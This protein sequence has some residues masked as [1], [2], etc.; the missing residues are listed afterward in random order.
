[1]KI[2]KKLFSVVLT[3]ILSVFAIKAV[4]AEGNGTITVKNATVGKTYEIYKIFDLTYS[5]AKVAYTIDSDW[6]LFFN[7]VG[8]KYIVDTNTT[9][10]LN[11]ITVNGVT[12]Y[13]NITDGTTGNV[14]EF[15]QDALAYIASKMTTNDLGESVPF[16]DGE[17]TAT[18]S[19]DGVTNVDLTFSNLDLGYY[20]VYPEGATDVKEGYASI[21]SL[22]STLP[23]AEVQIKAEYPTIDKTVDD[24]SVEVGQVVT[25]TISGMVPDTTGYSTYTY[26]ISDVMSVGLFFNEN[27]AN[28]KV[29]FGEDDKN[30]IED[31]RTLITNGDLD[32]IVNGFTLTFDMVQYQNYKGQLIT[33]TYDARVTEDAIDSTTTKN[34]ATLTYSND[35]KD[36]TSVVTTPPVEKYLYSADILVIKVD[37]EDN[38][39]KL[40][41]AKF[42][43]TKK[44]GE[45]VYYY[46]LTGEGND[47]V[48]S[49]STNKDDAT[50]YITDANGNVIFAGIEDGTYYLV[51]VEA[52]DGYNLLVTPTTVVVNNAGVGEN[53]V[54]VIQTVSATVENNSGIELPTTGGFGT[55]L[56]IIIGS[57]LAVVSAIILVTNKRMSKEF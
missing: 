39:V 22:T 26:T 41:G 1:M 4:S 3:L 53:T 50:P 18:S 31:E 47:K 38:N 36:V 29:Y 48:V 28:L 2:L 57:I 44:V 21:C 40:E 51:E 23:N 13:I 34:S 11:A 32:Y 24:Y 35:P 7:G 27:I 17:Q 14:A 19:E 49:W 16:N 12:K 43:L 25:F 42:I 30:T 8:S 52:P 56:F 20:L 5:G 55:K 15:A 46:K 37:G 33:V 10:N 54:P 6:T 9:G 45:T